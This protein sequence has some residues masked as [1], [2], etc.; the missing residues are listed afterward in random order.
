MIGSC[1]AAGQAV[2]VLVLESGPAW[3]PLVAT[4]LRSGSRRRWLGQD[5][6]PV[7]PQPLLGCSQRPLTLVEAPFSS[8]K[9]RGTLREP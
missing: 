5:Q 3:A 9:A 7:G 6:P 8:I 1:A 4:D 2:T